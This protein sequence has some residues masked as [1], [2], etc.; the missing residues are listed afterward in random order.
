M[1]EPRESRAVE[2]H[3]HMGLQGTC[4]F[5]FHSSKTGDSPCYVDRSG[6]PD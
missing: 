4:M 2:G 3:M 1:A 6:Q 5:L